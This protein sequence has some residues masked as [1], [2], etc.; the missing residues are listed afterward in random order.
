[1]RF[2]VTVQR[3]VNEG[4]RRGQK[5]KWENVFPETEDHDG[6]CW[7]AIRQQRVAE[8]NQRKQLVVIGSFQ[9]R[10]WKIDGLDETWRFLHGGHAYNIISVEQP[11]YNVRELV[12]IAKRDKLK[13]SDDAH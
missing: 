4:S 7:A 3:P 9:I 2:R 10:I 11:N 8:T 6:K 12:I 1:M 13:V 5:T